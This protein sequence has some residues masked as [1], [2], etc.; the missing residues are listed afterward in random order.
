MS[1][2]FPDRDMSHRDKIAWMVEQH[3]WAF[4]AVPAHPELDPPIPGYAYTIGL[5]SAFAFP[6]I[7]VFGLTPVASRGLVGLVVDFLRSGSELPV[8][9]LFTGLLD[10]GLRSALLPVD[11]GDYGEMFGA[12]TAWYETEPYRIVQ[13]A[14]PDRNGWLPWEAGFDHRLLMAQPIIGALDDVG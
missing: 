11:I 9:P 3:G 5:E 8:G 10:N 7:V 6:E 4:D 2:A 1:D 12:A 14:W 13:L